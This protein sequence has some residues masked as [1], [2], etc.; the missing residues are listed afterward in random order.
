MDEAKLNEIGKFILDQTKQTLATP[1]QSRTF[2]GLPK[3]IGGQFPTPVSPKVASR[4]YIDSLRYRVN[5][6]PKDKQP[7]IEIFSTLPEGQNYGPYIEEGRAPNERF[8]NYG[9]IES[10]IAEKPIIPKLLPQK[11]GKRI[12]YRIPTLK[13]LTFLISRSIFE[14][15][16]FP[17]PYAEITR[18]RIIRELVKKM[19][20]IV[21]QQTEK[22]IRENVIFQIDPKRRT[23]V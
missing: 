20:P 6:D 14:E 16:I 9:K 10:W 2:G 15:G 5:T 8:P 11:D 4:T 12:R 18:E 13:Q 23:R 21:A 22:F 3:P 19:E 7:I 1:V 17:Y